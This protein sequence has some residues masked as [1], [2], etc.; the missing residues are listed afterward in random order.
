MASRHRAQRCFLNL[1]LEG[2]LKVKRNA[3]R[4]NNHRV[5]KP[6]LEYD[7]PRGMLKEIMSQFQNE[8]GTL[9]WS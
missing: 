9:G 4:G 1:G 2:K 5:F 8:K 3:L 7:R 6:S